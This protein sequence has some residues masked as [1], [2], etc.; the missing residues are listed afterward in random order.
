MLWNFI[1]MEG[2]YYAGQRI[3]K[4]TATFIMNMAIECI[5]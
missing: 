5:L 1:Q 3:Y 4:K 2:V